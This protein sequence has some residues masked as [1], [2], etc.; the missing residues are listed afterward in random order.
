M[1]DFLINHMNAWEKLV[2]YGNFKEWKNQHTKFINAQF[3]KSKGF[4]NELI[5][6]GEKNKIIK[7]LGIKNKEATPI[8]FE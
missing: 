7:L 8:L 1:Y 3:E 2:K 5:K 6:K 4:Y